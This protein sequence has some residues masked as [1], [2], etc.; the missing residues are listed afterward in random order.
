[1]ELNDFLQGARVLAHLLTVLLVAGYCPD[2]ETT[3][4]PAISW[5]A[6]AL[7]GSSAGLAMSTALSWQA[8]LSI[9]LAGQF[10]LTF[11]FVLVLAPLIAGRGNVA[12]LFPRK[13][14]SQ[15]P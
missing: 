11:V 1:M 5:V 2:A 9:P 6:I 3:K 13:P 10:C 12:T 14:W 4:R 15:R 7:A 8:W